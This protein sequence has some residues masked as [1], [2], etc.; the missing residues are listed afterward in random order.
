MYKSVTVM[1]LQEF[2]SDSHQTAVV[3]HGLSLRIQIQL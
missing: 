1:P 3:F 2:A